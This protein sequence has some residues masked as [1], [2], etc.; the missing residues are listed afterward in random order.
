[1]IFTENG[2]PGCAENV[3]MVVNFRLGTLKNSAP[4]HKSKFRK[5]LDF[6]GG[7]GGPR[8]ARVVS[9]GCFLLVFW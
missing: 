3:A 2:D 7:P 8:E 5:R 6:F 9:G 1:M 4:V